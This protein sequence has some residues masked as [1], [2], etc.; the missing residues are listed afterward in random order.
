[1][2]IEISACYMSDFDY[3]FDNKIKLNSVSVI[4][5]DTNY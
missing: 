2:E 4:G 3:Y 1:M 5:I